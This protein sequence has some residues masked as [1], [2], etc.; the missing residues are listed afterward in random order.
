[1]PAG[2][3]GPRGRQA[4]RGHDEGA[5]AARVLHAAPGPGGEPDGAARERLGHELRPDLER[6]RRP[7]RA[8]A[9]QA[10]RAS[11]RASARDGAGRMPRLRPIETTAWTMA[12]LCG[13]PGSLETKARSTLSVSNGNDWR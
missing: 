10:A 2:P 13:S 5:R 11:G 7:R 8:A 4:P 6:D 1:G 12:T 3:G 9:R